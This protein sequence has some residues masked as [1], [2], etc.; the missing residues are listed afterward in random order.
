[1][2]DN[3]TKIDNILECFNN[4][5]EDNLRGYHQYLKTGNIEILKESTRDFIDE[6][7]K[8]RKMVIGESF[9]PYKLL[10]AKRN[11]SKNDV[12]VDDIERFT[13]KVIK[14]NYE[15]K[16]NAITDLKRELVVD[17]EY[18]I[19]ENYLNIADIMLQESLSYMCIESLYVIDCLENMRIVTEANEKPEN[20]STVNRNRDKLSNSVKDN[21][22]KVG[23][24]TKQVGNKILSRLKEFL[25]KVKTMFKQKIEKLKARD[26]KWLQ[27]NKKAI[28]NAKVDNLE[29]NVNSDYKDSY[30]NMVMRCDKYLNLYN[31][32]KYDD[33]SLDVKLE[34]NTKNY[35]DK[36][37]NLKQ[38]LINFY[39]TGQPKK[40]VSIVT[41]RGNEIKNNLD[42]LYNYCTSFLS[43]SNAVFKQIQDLE[44]KLNEIERVMDKRNI[45]ENFCYIE[46]DLLTNTDLALCENF[47]LLLE[48]D[49]EDK[50]KIG[51]QQRN[52]TEEETSKLSDKGVS[53]YNKM[54]RDEH[55]GL[56]AFLTA[57]EQKYF[58]T[59]KILRAIV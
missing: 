30:N 23:S 38:G 39:R 11:L 35:A 16:D 51:V 25:N 48:S 49:S 44:R 33:P 27:E 17:D 26:L 31:G 58:E 20:N 10:D 5:E 53:G 28:L 22:K 9:T 32:M 47:H 12:S 29:V 41:L 46:N 2:N 7:I 54:F 14:E 8:F 43:N 34:R 21:V 37:G 6:T 42:D 15:I 55:M 45:T 40:E 50:P 3:M 52:E 59:I 56:T 57:A 36:E 19:I 13:K 4:L 18:G 1:M 24:K